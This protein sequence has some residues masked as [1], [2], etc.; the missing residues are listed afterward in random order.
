MQEA[1]VCYPIVDD[2]TLLIR[3]QRGLGEGKLVGA[4]GKLE[5]GETPHACVVRELREELDVGLRGLEKAGVLNFH[6]GG[7]APD[8]DSIHTHVYTAEGIEGEPTASPEAVPVWEPLDD[9]RYD[10]MWVDDRIWFPHMLDGRTFTG[11]FV[12]SDGG[13]SVSEYELRLDVSFE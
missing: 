9:L 7:P 13:T 2:E 1:T 11:T 3:K 6:F 4:G 12:L 10:E 5:P 8:E